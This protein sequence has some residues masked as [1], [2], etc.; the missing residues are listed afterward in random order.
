MVTSMAAVMT[1]ISVMAVISVMT[2]V[3]IVRVGMNSNVSF[4]ST[5]RVEIGLEWMRMDMIFTAAIRTGQDWCAV[6]RCWGAV[7]WL[8]GSIAR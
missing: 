5:L 6:G 3:T 8:R 4:N 2:V 7:S 1:M